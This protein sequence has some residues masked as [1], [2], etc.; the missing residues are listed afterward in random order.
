MR[1]IAV[2]ASLLALCGCAA[3]PKACT[4]IGTRVGIGLDV[5]LPGVKSATLEVCWGGKCTKPAVTL[6]PATTNGRETCTGTAPTDTCGVSVVPTGGMIGFAE[7]VGLPSEPVTVTLTL[8]D[9]AGAVV[10]DEDLTV[11]PK[12]TYPNGPDCGG[13]GAQ[14]GLVVSAAGVVTERA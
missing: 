10:L 12:Q 7:V 6:T 8:A 4:L 5:D 9:S 11:T 3:E 14:A 1:I 2:I 13:G